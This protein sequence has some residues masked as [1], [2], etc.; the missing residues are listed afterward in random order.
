LS[1]KI[2][3]SFEI[4]DT[5]F[6]DLYKKYLYG[7]EMQ[8]N[9]V[10]SEIKRLKS[11]MNWATESGHNTNLA[12]KSFK[13]PKEK[14][15]IMVLNQDELNTIY[16]FDLSS[17]KRL[18]RVRDLFVLGCYTGLR[19]SDIANL[20]K[21]N[22]NGNFIELRTV[23][24]KDPLKIPIAPHAR[25]IIIKYD[26]NL[27]KISNQKANDYIKEI[28]QTVGLESKTQKVKYNG[29]RRIDVTVNKFELLTTHTARRTFITLALKQGMPQVT[30]IKI[31]G[32][33]DLRTM[34]KYV[35]IT[36]EDTY[37]AMMKIFDNPLSVMKVV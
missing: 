7:L 15:T 34:Q 18:E 16:S 24:T 30:L 36:E 13:K 22:I 28:G 9:T 3:L 33:K 17:N 10:G 23:K 21:E 27:P 26:G 37:N 4:V 20:K 29:G 35:E 5:K 14:T 32:H 31:T 1:K 6:Y 11:F 12:F 25:E 19:F 2:K 8:P